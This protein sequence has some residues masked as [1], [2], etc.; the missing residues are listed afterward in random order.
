MWIYLACSGSTSSQESEESQRPSKGTLPLSPIVRTTDTLK[1]CCC[2]AWRAENSQERLLPTMFVHSAVVNFQLL[3]SFTADFPVRTLALQDA[4]SAWVA[5]EADYFSRSLD[6]LAKYD[7]DSSSWK[8]FLLS[9]PVGPILS[10]AK[11]PAW[12]MTVDGSLYPLRKS[13][14]IIGVSGGGYW[15]TPG[16]NDHKHP[17]LPRRGTKSCSGHSLA[18][19]V[20][21]PTPRAREWKGTGPLGSKSQAYRL[22]KGYLDA[23]VQERGQVTG[24][25]NPTFVEWLMGYPSEWT[26]LE[27]WA[28]A[29]FRPKRV[30]RLKG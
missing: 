10:S 1:L 14:R 12:G 29:W 6:S 22:K 15:P 21:W 7:P 30:K 17:G 27:P 5:S 8:T 26:A 25:L 23:T 28:I 18:A 24:Q 16:A 13:G 3:T 2:H 20:T 4:E 19:K 11:W 9:D